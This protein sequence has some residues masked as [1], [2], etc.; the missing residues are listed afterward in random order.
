MDSEENGVVGYS[1]KLNIRPA[2]QREFVY[3]DKQRNAVIETVVKGFPLNVM[4]WVEDES[5]N[6]ELLDGQQRTISIC[7]YVNGDFSLDSRAFHNL[8]ET[9]KNK[10]LFDAGQSDLFL[11]NAEMLGEKLQDVDI[12]ILSHGH[13]DHGNGLEYFMQRNSRA[14]IYVHPLAF[15]AF[16]HGERYIGLSEKVKASQDR[17]AMLDQKIDLDQDLS[18]LPADLFSEAKPTD[19]LIKCGDALVPDRFEHELYLVVTQGNEKVLFTGCCHRGILAVLEVAKQN[20]ITHIVGGFHLTD[21]LSTEQLAIIAEELRNSRISYYSGHCTHFTAAEHL[22]KVLGKRFHRLASGMMFSIGGKPE[23]AGT[24]FRQGYNC[25]QAV[26]GAFSEEL[27]LP[28][29]TAVK[30]SCSFGGGMGRMREVCG[31]VSGMFMVAGF[32]YGTT[33]KDGEA[34]KAA[35]YALIQE[36]ARRF[37]EKNNGTIIC[38]ELLG[39]LA[40]AKS[41]SPTPDKRCPEYYNTRPCLKFVL[42]AVEIMEEI[43]KERE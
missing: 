9:E 22:S 39:N 27:G 10:I 33:D 42:D 11:R 41:T 18:V 43:I 8:T 26:L 28:F 6:F 32:L 21:T 29:E 23:L 5:G 35:H 12:V 40:A 2:F 7:Q 38:R 25:S 37:K 3:K 14:K 20:G 34:E 31:A 1:G 15:A 24:L 17:F 13:Y 4:Y 19:L 36:M 16:F 30:L